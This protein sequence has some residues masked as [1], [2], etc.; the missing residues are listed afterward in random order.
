MN[1]ITSLNIQPD[2]SIYGVFSRLNYKIWYALAEFVDNSTASFFK[3]ERILKFYKIDKCKIYITYNDEDDILVIKD[4]AYGMELFDFER[5]IKLDQKPE[6]LDGRNEFGMG[7]KTAA[8]WFGNLWSVESTQ[9]GSV[10]KYYAEV[11]IPYLRESKSNNIEVRSSICDLNEHGTTVTIRQLTKKIEG[12]RTIGK[13]KD[14]IRSM[15]RRDINSGKIEIYFNNDPLSF[16]AYDVLKYDS[17]EWKKKISFSFIFNETQYTVNGFVG[18]LGEKSSGFTK[19]GFALFRRNRIVIGGEGDYYKPSVIFGQAQSKISHKLFGEL[20]LDDFPINQ[21]KDGFIWDDGL[22]TKFLVE[23]K[24]NISEYIKIADKSIKE[25]NPKVENTKEILDTVQSSVQSSLTK[26]NQDE[27][28]EVYINEDSIS[29]IEKFNIEQEKIVIKEKLIQD[30]LHTYHV[31]INKFDLMKLTV[32]WT[33]TGDD[34]WFTKEIVKAN[35]LNLKINISHPFFEPFYSNS[36]FKVVMEKFA[37][38]FILTSDFASRN[39]DKDGYVLP[40]EFENTMNRLL[41]ILAKE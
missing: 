32:T 14:L 39:S 7:L 27:G 15:Y 31:P 33:H 6:N 24:N 36:N 12:G 10:N 30:S 16:E 25:L 29:T 13:I 40:S 37:I 28:L 21:S 41:S 9:L 1:N 4:D 35:E 20:D 2:A 3:A 22:E 26:I 5:A 19:A 18:I 8:S 23:L 34:Y 38:G 11:N 17:E